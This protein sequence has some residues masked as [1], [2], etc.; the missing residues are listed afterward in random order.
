MTNKEIIDGGV[1]NFHTYIDLI[2]KPIEFDELEPH[3][4]K[5]VVDGR[6]TAFDAATDQLSKVKSLEE[7]ESL[8]VED[9]HRKRLETLVA[10]TEGIWDE[11]KKVLSYKIDTELLDDDKVKAVVQAKDMSFDLMRVIYSEKNRI[12][13]RLNSEASLS[14]S[15]NRNFAAE[16]FKQ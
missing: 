6:K 7:G 16:R 3:K 5:S 14:G 1:E 12:E 9:V 10:S 8:F 11:I 13:Q 2:K 15:G 4:F